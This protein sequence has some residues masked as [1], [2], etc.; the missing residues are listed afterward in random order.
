MRPGRVRGTQGIPSIAETIR[1]NGDGS[2]PYTDDSLT[3]S[4]F[5]NMS[6]AFRSSPAH[7]SDIKTLVATS[8]GFLVTLRNQWTKR[9]ALFGDVA[10]LV[11]VSDNNG[12][13]LVLTYGP[14]HR[15]SNIEG[16][17][18][19]FIS[20][21]RNTMGQ[22]TEI[23]DDQGRS[24]SY[25]YNNQ[26]ELAVVSDLGGNDWEYRYANR[27][28]HQ[29]VDP[30]GNR[31]ALISYH[32][33]GR[34]KHT[35]IRHEKHSYDYYGSETTVTD[36]MGDSSQFV[37]N[38]LGITAYII[39]SDNFASEIDLTPANN[40]ATL[41]HN[42]RLRAAFSYDNSG[43]PERI[44]RFDAEGE[45]ELTYIFDWNDRVLA[46]TG[47]DGESQ[48]LVY[49]TRGNLIRRT[50]N[51][52]TV[53]F[54]FDA[55]GD[56]ISQNEDGEITAYE[57]SADGLLEQ[58]ESDAGTSQFVYNS[59]GRLAAITFPDGS[60]HQYEYDSLGFRTATTRA[61]GTWQDFDYDSTGNL[62]EYQAIS[63]Y[64]EAYGQ[65]LILNSENQVSRIEFQP[66]GQ[67]DIK[68]N[69][70]GNPKSLDWGDQVM[71]CEYDSSGRLTSIQS[72]A[73]GTK[74]YQYKDG[75]PDIRKQLD[76]RT[77]ASLV[78]QRRASNTFGSL[79]EIHY[80]R[81]HGSFGTAVN[82]NEELS[83]LDL[84]TEV[85][86]V[87]PDSIL[88]A[89]DQR[90][91]L[92]NTLAQDPILQRAFDKASNS[93]FL[94]PEYSSANCVFTQTATPALT[95]PATAL[96][97]VSVNITASVGWVSAGCGPVIWR[98]WANS[99]YIGGG[100]G[101]FSKTVSTVFSSAGTYTITVSVRCS[102][103]DSTIKQATAN[104]DVQPDACTGSEL[105]N[106][107]TSYAASI[108]L[109]KYER[110]TSIDCVNGEPEQR[111]PL[112][113]IYSQPGDEQC[114][115]AVTKFSG[116]IAWVHTH[117]QFI[118]GET[119]FCHGEEVT[120]SNPQMVND[121]NFA[122]EE[123]SDADKAISSSEYPGFLKT[124]LGNIR[125]WP[126]N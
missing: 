81:S 74:D 95:V 43:N 106:W 80:V 20:I 110:G 22:V 79:S 96:T 122:A 88:Q 62:T 64:G 108:P 111:L 37:Q 4:H 75:E 97:G 91:R 8:D 59:Q 50:H 28:L 35:K 123:F 109:R 36:D 120:M 107:A 112:Q 16:Q 102:Y 99:S 126:V 1:I 94:P 90:R 113:Q 2:L 101:G 69:A 98:F 84:P 100:S 87:S 21:F 83:I 30:E 23:T 61:D 71:R 70:D 31:A 3:V 27:Q 92:Y 78:N 124:S 5:S 15:L 45:V 57:Y 34:V 26:G 68:Y 121:Y 40:V 65:K 114:Q 66:Q 7:P 63:L 46:I 48:N 47:T 54:E 10:R 103:G 72:D 125:R 11:E 9:F 53:Q 18:G 24:V 32:Q 33:D 105:D 14:D 51:G 73:F 29:V 39:N 17:N 41:R 77:F 116:D 52:S 12:N 119:Y 19:R 85:G 117:P 55:Q 44:V 89:A 38:E 25:S 60:Q 56:L 67:L 42:G 104:I 6:G 82:W 118:L 13:T 58:L 115:I 76:E 49:D 86:L 93:F